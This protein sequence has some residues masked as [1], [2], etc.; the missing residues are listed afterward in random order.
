MT[1]TAYLL[2][3]GGLALLYFGGEFLLRGAV[4]VALRLKLPP[5]LIGLTIVACA[6]S[7]PELLVTVTAG[8]EG[9][10]DVGV[11][12]IVGSNIANILLILGVGAVIKPI[13]INPNMGLRDLYVML[14]A[15]AAFIFFALA[16]EFD[17]IHSLGMLLGLSLYIWFSYRQDRPRRIEVEEEVLEEVGEK[18]CSIPFA[19]LLLA[20]GLGGLVG[21]SEMLI[22]GAVTLARAAG[23]SETVIGLTLVAIGTSLPELATAIVAGL[24]GHSDVALGNVIGSNIFNI[25]LIIGVLALI[26]PFTVAEQ[27]VS[28]DMWV[29]GAVSLL[30]LPFVAFGWRIGR[31]SGVL[32]LLAYGGYIAFQFLNGGFKV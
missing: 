3:G 10:S 30:V 11:G 21:G 14:L 16:G 22:D 4:S 15:T 27:V 18:P 25:L 7:M 17:R 1:A 12:N 13:D 8:L 32:F 28:L 20:L 19:L 26:V 24:R 29:M 6:T 5:L 2:T 9:V 23:V 31:S